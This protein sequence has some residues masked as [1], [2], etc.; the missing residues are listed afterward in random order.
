[1]EDNELV[2][3]SF[4]ATINAPIE[5]IDIPSWCFTLPESEYQW[6]SPAHCSAGA[7]TSPDGRR[8]SI[9]VEILGGSLF[10]QH[11]I[12]EVARPESSKTGFHVIVF[13]PSGR[14]KIGAI[15]DR[16]PGR[17]TIRHAIQTRFKPVPR[18][19]R[20]TSSVA[21]GYRWTCSGVPINR[22]RRPTTGRRHR[23]SQKAS[24]V[25]PYDQVEIDRREHGATD[26]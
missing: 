8:M 21:R 23:C 9:N 2:K 6:C 22:L 13:T 17:S 1:M 26:L 16:Q 10:V 24:N 19:H 5:K 15:W 7:T 11:Y 12:E 25:M 4:S 3:S 14:T 18:R 20:H